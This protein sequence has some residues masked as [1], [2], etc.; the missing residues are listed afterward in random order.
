MQI[1]G[2][3]GWWSEEIPKNSRQA[4]EECFRRGFGTETDV[5]DFDGQLV[6]AHD[7]VESSATPMLL[8]ELLEVYSRYKEPGTLALNVKSDGLA[9]AIAREIET[10]NL[11]NYVLFDMSVPDM[12]SYR[13]QGL[14]YLVRV[15]EYE[16]ICQELLTPCG[17]WLDG[18]VS[19]WFMSDF[20]DEAINDEIP[21]YIVSSE[22]HRRDPKELWK[23]L[24]GYRESDITICTDWPE[25]AREVLG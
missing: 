11:S 24:S 1:I 3:R 5:R 2:H 4:L 22:L 6:I 19:D 18:F 8:T 21:I 7:M 16:T 13:R 15:S 9:E 12:L 20:I 14:N 17:I 10:Y 23:R 25:S